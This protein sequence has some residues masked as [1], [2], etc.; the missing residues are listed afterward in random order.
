MV[1]WMNRG[2]VRV[3]WTVEP[4]IKT[5]QSLD[6]AIAGATGVSAGSAHN[7]P[8]LLMPDKVSGWSWSQLT[9]PVVVG[10]DIVDQVKC[11]RITGTAYK[12]SQMTI[13]IGQADHLIRKLVQTAT[14]DSQTDTFTTTT[15]YHPRPNA[16]LTARNFQQVAKTHL[17]R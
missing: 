14:I 3:W 7:V 12:D 5:E 4:K 11:D 9:S 13:W 10:A 1:V 15:T 6:M 8:R 2:P 16:K 17:Q